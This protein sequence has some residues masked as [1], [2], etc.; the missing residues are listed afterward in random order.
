[1]FGTPRSSPP[2]R[3]R[4]ILALSTLALLAFCCLPVLAQA[5]SAG[6]EYNAATP[7]PTG[8]HPIQEKEPSEHSSNTGGGASD[9]NGGAG[10]K[11]PSADDTSKQAGHGSDAVKKGTG[12]PQGSQ[13]KARKDGSKGSEVGG[14]PVASQGE[15]DSSSPVAAILIA[16]A[17]LAAITIGAVVMRQRRRGDDV[18]PGA[19]AAPKAS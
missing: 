19:P 18:E 5:D 9:S 12:Q 4:S 15:D 1:M 13:G 6:I 2:R 11:S 10:G 3:G 16:V 7:T 8:N 14:E 17:V